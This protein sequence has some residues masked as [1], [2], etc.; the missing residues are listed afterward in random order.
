MTSAQVQRTLVKSPPELWAELSDPAS[1]AR[2]LGELGEIRITRVEPEHKV[3]WTADHASG[4]VLIKPSAWGTRVTLT[5]SREHS[6][7][8]RCAAA[9]AP[10][11]L[12][13]VR[14]T[15]P[16]QFA[17]GRSGPALPALEASPPP[18]SP[19]A[20]PPLEGAAALTA[21]AESAIAS[22]RDPATA[23]AERA[24]AAEPATSTRDDTSAPTRD[25]P[26]ARRDHAGTSTQAP[27]AP[28]PVAPEGPPGRE[29]TAPEPAGDSR[30]GFFARLLHRLRG[31]EPVGVSTHANDPPQQAALAAHEPLSTTAR[32]PSPALDRGD[33]D[34]LESRAEEPQPAVP[35]PEPTPEAATA[36]TLDKPMDGPASAQQLPSQREG[37]AAP[38]ASAE[39]PADDVTAV[40][41]SVLD[42]LGAAHHRPFS[43][44]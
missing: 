27:A 39:A 30:R 32:A 33:D 25:R 28:E 11:A 21:P 19:S 44:P 6:G 10:G 42:R 2:H 35:A 4:S 14:P 22:Q 13:S 15:P 9:A 7:D 36:Q 18:A 34:S 23:P 1:L 38:P 12:A 26:A 43:R 29:P 5:A 37:G 17:P 16:P 40:L 24:A 31:A 20:Q 41:N 8:P 3:E